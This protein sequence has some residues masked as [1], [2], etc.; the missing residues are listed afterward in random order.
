LYYPNNHA[1]AIG[2][3]PLSA[4]E[5]KH[6][7]DTIVHQRSISPSTMSNLDKWAEVPTA[8]PTIT[9][10]QENHAINA[11]SAL[12]TLHGAQ[13]KAAQKPGITKIFQFTAEKRASDLTQSANEVESLKSGRDP[14]TIFGALG[15]K[16]GNILDQTGVRQMGE[17]GLSMP[18]LA[19]HV[20]RIADAAKSFGQDITQHVGAFLK[21][22]DN[23]EQD[24][25]ET[26]E[27]NTHSIRPD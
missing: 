11:I 6:V 21:Q 25:R 10:D 22:A 27:D 4:Q 1:G 3:E 20:R 2:E 19:H 5:K 16:L 26:R 12:S 15:K 17:G 9:P 13:I 14:Q 24:A 7:L 8:W 23:A 18:D